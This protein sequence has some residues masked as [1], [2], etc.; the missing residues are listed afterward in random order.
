ARLTC[1]LH[2]AVF[3]LLDGKRRTDFCTRRRFAMHTDHRRGLRRVCR[4]DEV[5]V[6]H[7]DPFVGVAFGAGLYTRLTTNAAIGVHEEFVLVWNWHDYC[8]GSRR[9]AYSGG[10]AAFST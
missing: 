2:H 3:S 4:V 6:N 10:P 9:S 8:C 1:R 7:R 5:E